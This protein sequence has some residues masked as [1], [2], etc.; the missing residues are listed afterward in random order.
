M[1]VDV[2]PG[3]LLITAAG[4]ADAITPSTAAVIPVHLYGQPVDMTA[5]LAVADRAGSAVIEDAAQAHG[6]RWEG[7][8]VGSSARAACFSF[9]P[10]KTSEP[11]VTVVL[12]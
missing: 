7:R 2:D 4:V 6:A 1:F 11:L 12:S 5:I 3:T 8:R 10:G 9:Y